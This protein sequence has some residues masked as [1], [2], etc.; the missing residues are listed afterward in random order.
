MFL[1]RGTTR[2]CVSM[3]TLHLDCDIYNQNILIKL[4]ALLFPMPRAKFYLPSYIL[5]LV[6][7]ANFYCIVN[8]NMPH[9]NC[10]LVNPDLS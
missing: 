6:Y 8:M 9:V 2:Y 4:T 10:S 5:H 3:R 1:H 7:P